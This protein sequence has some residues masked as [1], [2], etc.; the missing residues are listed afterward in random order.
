MFKKSLIAAAIGLVAVGSAHAQTDKARLQAVSAANTLFISGAS[1]PRS[2]IV[3]AGTDAVCTSGTKRIFRQDQSTGLGANTL[4]LYGIVCTGNSLSGASG[5]DIAIY[6][7]PLGSLWGVTPVRRALPVPRLNLAN[8]PDAGSTG[9]SVTCTGAALPTQAAPDAGVSDLSKN[10]VAIAPNVPLAADI[11]AEFTLAGIVGATTKNSMA[12]A[13]SSAERATL[14]EKATG[15]TIF[16]VQVNKALRDALVARGGI[17][18]TSLSDGTPVLSRAEIASL[19]IS[20]N[21]AAGDAAALLGVSA[22][23][24]TLCRRL[25]GSGTQAVA[26]AYFLNNPVSLSVGGGRSFATNADDSFGPDSSYDVQ[27]AVASSDVA[28]CMNGAG[29]RMGILSIENAVPTT[30]GSGAYVA[31]NGVAATKANVRNGVYD[32]YSEQVLLQSGLSGTKLA[33]FNALDANALSTQSICS[34]AAAMVLPGVT[35]SAANASCQ[36]LSSRQGN[37]GGVN[38]SR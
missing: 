8:C 31:I 13:L 14:T 19:M 18:T 33:I 17:Y 35:V 1:A 21:P 23:N 7:S 37:Q 2:L 11:D 38:A 12:T 10:I 20:G 26:N 27:E 9:D 24:F 15:G 4:R 36:M 28:T 3:G 22:G 16:G 6:Y 25:T 5:Q 32:Y 30:G 29:Y 34:N